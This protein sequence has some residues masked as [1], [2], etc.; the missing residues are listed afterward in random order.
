MSGF[1][2]E[3]PAPQL[4][5]ARAWTHPDRPVLASLDTD[6]VYTFA[7]LH[8]AVLTWAGA[9]RAQGVDA[10]DAVVVMLP[11]SPDSYLA[12]LGLGWLRALEVPVNTNYQGSILTHV[13]NSSR[14]RVAVISAE[15]LG[16]LDAVAAELDT[17][18]T[19]IVP[20]G[21]PPKPACASRLLTRE[22]FLDGS[23]PPD[24]L[25]GPSFG[26]PGAVIF[27]SGTTGPSKGVLVPWAQIAT[28]W[29]CFPPD[30]FDASSRL[31]SF[32]PT[33]H[34]SGKWPLYGAIDR[35]SMLYLRERWKTERFW[36]DVRANAITHC[37]IFGSF[38]FFL[39]H[40]APQPDD[41]DN[42]LQHVVM[43]PVVPDY[44]D[45]EARFGVKVHTAWGMT[46][47]GLPMIGY[48]PLP[49]HLT[50]GSPASGYEVRLVDEDGR[51]VGAGVVGQALIRADEP[52]WLNQGYL[53]RPEASAE[54]WQDG[55]FRTGDGLKYDEDGNWYFV[56]RLKDCLR[57]RGEN[58]SSFEVEQEVA[59]HPEVLECAAVAVPSEWG[60]DDVKVVVVRKTGSALPE[61]EL[62][63]YLVERMARFMV[64]RYIEF[65][66][67]IPKTP[68]GK[69]R[70]AELRDQGVTAS[71]WDRE[72][73]NPRRESV[74]RA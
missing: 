28:M 60:E 69:A 24:G 14:A 47:V 3:A 72:A 12:W 23:R 18:E 45:F 7:Q 49:N 46:E 37:A 13:I 9:F 74:R 62:T 11:S 54:A 68:T 55:W 33:F 40:Q 4:L 25:T 19:I 50:C 10:G 38:P 26:D 34:M 67:E 66:N 41:A 2:A 51:A 57:R 32:W 48:H 21:P 42:P 30:T 29:R 15:F 58:I 8:E 64:P 39:K 53:N 1:P 27:T 16:R 22:E 35:T 63:D 61:A 43:A 56:D 20:D 73:G 36:D 59:S 52:S 17:L 31:Y 70:K 65:V 6:S 71:T 44:R 5:E